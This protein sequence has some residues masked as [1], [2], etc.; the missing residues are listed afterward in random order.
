MRA[1]RGGLAGILSK[2]GVRYRKETLDKVL[3]WASQAPPGHPHSLDLRLI[4][5][6]LDDDRLC[7]D[8]QIN[9]LERTLD[10]SSGPA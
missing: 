4:L 7:K 1:G 10:S 2:A 3:A 5:C 9:E 8:R 6:A